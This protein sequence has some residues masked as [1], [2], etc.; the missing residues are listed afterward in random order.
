MKKATKIIRCERCGNV[1]EPEEGSI[2]TG[3]GKD[4][5]NRIT[6]YSC[7]AEADKA[8]LFNAKLGETFYYYYTEP[9]DYKHGTVSNW[10]GSL[11]INAYYHKEGR[12]NLAG[13]RID[14][15]FK[16]KGNLFWGY[17][18]NP[19]FNQVARIKR[20]KG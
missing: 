18:L 11:K 20:I 13:K 16:Y 15:W 17:V 7:C 2:S 6:C 8:A 4:I 19:D 12:H 5:G 10:P 14:F 3:Y 1:I 9:E